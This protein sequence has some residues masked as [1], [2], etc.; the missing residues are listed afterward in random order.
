[1][2]RSTESRAEYASST[3]PATASGNRKKPANRRIWARVLP[4]SVS[5]SSMA[6]PIPSRL[7]RAKPRSRPASRRA[8]PGRTDACVG[9]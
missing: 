9:V 3:H 1:M 5:S 8:E 2:P 6:A 4:R 7:N